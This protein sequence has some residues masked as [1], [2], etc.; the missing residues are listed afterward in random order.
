ML[1]L[2]NWQKG[3][4]N[5]VLKLCLSDKTKRIGEVIFMGKRKDGKGCG[6]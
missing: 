2:M 4:L 3:W 5:K 6:R 1:L